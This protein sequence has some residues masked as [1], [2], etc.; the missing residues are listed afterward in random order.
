MTKRCNFSHPADDLTKSL[1]PY[2]VFIA[3]AAGSVTLNIIYKGLLLLVLSILMIKKLCVLKKV[4]PIYCMSGLQNPY[5]I[6]F[7]TKMANIGTLF[8]TKMAEKV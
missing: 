3:I 6:N 5:P 1:L 8:M 2:T 4:Y 7:M